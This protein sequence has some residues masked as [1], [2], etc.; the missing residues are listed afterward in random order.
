MLRRPAGRLCKDCIEMDF[1]NSD[2]ILKVSKPSR[3]MGHEINAVKKNVDD[4]DVSIALAFPDV[5]EVGM[6]HQGLKILYH[7]LNGFSWIAAE[8]V[9]CPWPDMEDEIRKRGLVLSS[10]ESGK[11]LKDFEILGFSVQHELCFTNILTM[12]DLAGIPFLSAERDES[13]PLVVAGGPACF[14][15][16]P[17]A[18]IFDAILIGDGEKAVVDLCKII[19]DAK[20]SKKNKNDVLNLLSKVKGFYIPSFFRPHYDDNKFVSIEAMLPDYKTVEKALIGDMT[21]SPFPVKQVVPY[22]QLVHDRLAIEISRGCTRGCRF[23][24]A[25]M[26]YRP[27]R[28]RSPEDIVDASDSA[29]KSTGFDELSLLSLSSGDYSGIAPLLKKLMDRQ[30][31]KKVA[32]S[33]P[34][35]RIDSIDPLWMEQIKRV[36]KTGFTMAPEAG[37]DRLRR[38]INKTLTNDEIIRASANVYKAGWKLIK[39][40]FMI[41]LPGENEDDLKGIIDLAKEVASCGRGKGKKDVLNISVSTFVPKAHTPFMWEPQ[42]EYEESWRRINFIR[43]GLRGTH[44]NVRWNQPELS[45]LEGIFSRGDRNLTRPLIMAWKTGARFDA[46]GEYYN[47]DLWKESFKE[48]G[49]DPHI[50][51][52]RKRSPD[53]DMPWAHISSGVDAEYFKKE[54]QKAFDAIT[55]PDCRKKCLKCGVCDFTDIKPVINREDSINEKTDDNAEMPAPSMSK[56]KFRLFFSKLGPARYISHL[57]LIRLLIRAL[58]RT[59][60]DMVFSEGYHP[61][62]KLSFSCA[63]PVGTESVCETADVELYNHVSSG[64]LKEKL[65]AE[66]PDGIEISDVKDITGKGKNVVIRESHYHIDMTGLEINRQDM[67][68]FINLNYFG[69]VK[70]TKKGE[71]EVDARKMVKGIRFGSDN[72][73]ELE[74][75]HS[76][77]P[78]LKPVQIIAAIFS[79]DPDN[80]EKI[81]VLKVR[82]ITG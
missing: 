64:A 25:G 36:R 11:R 44:V 32:V 9:F 6:S 73:V 55:T 53:E 68:S 49:I 70:R 22:T 46:W 18:D 10:L 51:L 63:M 60:L 38:I 54:L 72:N 3:Y 50:Y 66:L 29:L 81:R 19:S 23:C 52:H 61:M 28:E 75:L 4:V 56:K 31:D 48:C 5:Y 21:E 71:K 1:I 26:I 37:T 80:M 59:G 78:E 2:L 45:W 30:A 65:N 24:Q 35:L 20:K 79:I 41:G 69:V 17:I 42:I 40:Y 7:I 74:I 13:F 43:D 62:P 76:E 58:R 15:P 77:G 57:E 82:Q 14:N 33:L 47:M 27:V 34:S 39:L 8:R 12:L 16:E 67:D